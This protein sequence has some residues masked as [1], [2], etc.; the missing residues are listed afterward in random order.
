LTMRITIGRVVAVLGLMAAVA[1]IAWSVM[2]RPIP[3]ETAAVTKG[4]F[5]ASVDEDGKTRVRERYVV[6][7]PLAG[8]LS[9][10]RLKVG[11]RIGVDD[12]VATIA[13]SPVPLLDPRSRREAEERLGGAEAT[14]DRTQAATERAKAQADQAKTEL[15]RTRTL[16][17]RGASTTQA[18][19]RAELAMRVAD[20]D[21]R[22]AD[23]LHHSAEH[24]INQA[25][26][27]LARYQ[28][29]ANSASDAWNVSA[30]VPGVVLKVTQE[31][32]TIVQPGTP[33]I[34]I[35][36]PRDLEIVVDVLSTDA[37]EIRPGA[38]VVIERW[39]GQGVLAGRVRRVEPAAFTKVSTLGVEEQRVNVLIDISASPEQWAGLGDAFQVDARITV[40][41]QEDATIVPTGALFRRGETWN[42]FVVADGRAQDREIKL[43][44]RSGRFAA[45]AAGLVPGE[46]VIVYPSDRIASGGRVELR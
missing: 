44:R 27:L 36:D 23:F 12:V 42:V 31:S 20:R 10:I 6:A 16:V 26:A 30:P 8:R 43:L 24:E 15:D 18:L 28:D 17:D 13:P 2:P 40:F 9:R 34:E 46:R 22:V 1:G 14:L 37:V 45:V 38:E 7:A 19:E 33:L 35:S 41:T 4:L 5:V 11:D 3:V 32:E 39:G 25:R 29:G 21:L